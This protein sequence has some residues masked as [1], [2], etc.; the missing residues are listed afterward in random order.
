MSPSSLKPED[1]ELPIP[2]PYS[3]GPSVY[4]LQETPGA[5]PPDATSETNEV[6]ASV[7]QSLSAAVRARRDEY[8]RKRSIKIKVGTWNVAS[9]H[10]T[11]KDLGAWFVKGLGVRGLSQKVA[12]LALDGTPDHDRERTI[13]SVSEQEERLSAKTS[14]VP[15][16]DVPAGDP[17]DDI[18]LYVL[19]LQEVVDVAS[20][21]EAMKPYTDPNPA[22]KWKAAL[23]DVLP[24]GYEKVASYQLLGLLILVFASPDVLP[25]VSSVS[26]TSV[27]TGLMGYLGNKGAVIVRLVLGE[28]TRLCFVNCHL[29]AG[30]DHAA[31]NR[32]IWDTSQIVARARFQPAVID[33]EQQHGEEKI[34]DEDFAFW[35]GDLN[36]R[37]DDIPGEDVRRLLLL[38][39]RNEY[40]VTNKSRRKIDSELG[41]IDAS[42]DQGADS[43]P[44]P[45]QNEEGGNPANASSAEPPSDPRSDPTSLVTTIESLLSHDQLRAAQR[46]KKAF[47]DGWREGQINFLPTYKYDVGSV[48]MFDSGEKKRSPSWCDRILY[49]S[50]SD[51]LMYEEKAKQ[52]TETRRKDDEMK[53]KGLDKAAAEQDVLFD[54]DPD[55]DGLAYGDEY[56]EEEDNF[57]DA[58]LVETNQGFDDNIEIQQY[59]SHQR[60]LSSDHK[61]LDAVFTMT[62]DAVMP[63]LRA[64]VQQDVAKEFDKAENEGRPTITLV[65]DQHA[66]GQAGETLNK[67]DSQD[68][69]S[70]HF[71]QL[72]Y[73]VAATRSVTIANTGQTE[74]TFH[75]ISTGRYGTKSESIAPEWLTLHLPQHG[76]RREKSED[77]SKSEQ[78]EEH[79]LHPGE[80]RLVEMTAHVSEPDLV[81]KLNH[82]QAELDDVL[83]L[84]V[85]NGRDYFLPVK[86]TW[87]PSCFC[88]SLDELVIASDKG[89]RDLAKSA[90]NRDGTG[91]GGL[92][93]SPV[94]HSAPKELFALIKDFLSLVERSIADW[95]MVHP[96][97]DP[98]WL[99]DNGDNTWPFEPTLW[100]FHS[101]EERSSLLAGVREALDTA[102]PVE[103][104]FPE[105]TAHIVKVEVLAETILSF[106]ANLVD[107][108]ITESMWESIEPQLATIEKEKIRPSAEDLQ[109]IAMEPLSSAPVHSVSMTFLTFMLTRTVNEIVPSSSEQTKSPTSAASRRS[110]ASSLISDAGSENSVEGSS[111]RSFLK[112]LRRRRGNS[113]SIT[114]AES[115][116]SPTVDRRKVLLK[117]Y[118][119]LFAPLIVR[120]ARDKTAKGKDRI[121]LDSRK[122]RIVEAFLETA[123]L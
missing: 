95:E 78:T 51:R 70:V 79:T 62:Y 24:Q 32:R 88:R 5:F 54:Y 30:A 13:E 17:G 19:G 1:A 116:S 98:P 96:D 36:Y 31:L 18:G 85:K 49:R 89:V 115:E 73:D 47:H 111:K 61:P 7:P 100:T 80:T 38:H 34:G 52:E 16:N 83:I 106:L 64:K 60:V 69:N 103:D 48:G 90:K 2:S 9:I 59:I 33:G 107:G 105:D 41:Y 102:E 118:A 56:D 23:R 101:G 120:S 29:A 28:T 43:S 35:F 55:T 81:Y 123:Q 26:C 110:R 27:G 108:I 87:L 67:T 82:Q 84:S 68:V 4:T 42:S 75:F 93:S 21:T 71:G 72:R 121:V 37:M 53:K 63:E 22:K 77:A 109:A 114:S 20:V 46:L 44:K 99:H 117:N 15:K 10:G 112:S 39:T 65:V 57:H 40:D 66:D 104:A 12:G 50:R 92:K 58:E 76:E 8:T 14:T 25:L 91:T 45:N 119:A 97:E 74:A 86:G 94:H 113:Q 122:R 3:P 11:E 6:G